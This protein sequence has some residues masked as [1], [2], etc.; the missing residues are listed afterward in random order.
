MQKSSSLPNKIEDFFWKI[1]EI[2]IFQKIS[3]IQKS[4]AIK[5]TLK[6]CQFDSN[7]IRKEGVTAKKLSKLQAK[8]MVI[9]SNF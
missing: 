3:L 7:L 6:K 5:V 2:L 4:Q 8:F 1:F 9:A